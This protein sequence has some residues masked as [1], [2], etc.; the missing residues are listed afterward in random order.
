VAGAG[1]SDPVADWLAAVASRL[2]GPA[3]SR[4]AVTDELRDGLLETVERQLARG[5]SRREATATAIAEFGDPATVAAA[6][7]PELA[8]VQARRVALS[9]LATGPLVGLAWLAA[10]AVNGL[11]PW[12][13]Q[14]SGP[15]LALPLVGLAVL[16]A[17]PAL[18]LTV[19]ATG[20]LARRLGRLGRRATLPATAVVVAGL[21]AVVADLTM[22]AVMTGQALTTAGPDVWAPIVIAAGASLTRVTLAGRATRRCLATRASLT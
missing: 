19:A 15:W 4:V 9:L 21:A 13:H 10:A 16:V 3:G 11:P 14:L 20:R 8:A 18:G 17:C 22:L 6:F 2:T 12:R 1:V 5:R 7:G